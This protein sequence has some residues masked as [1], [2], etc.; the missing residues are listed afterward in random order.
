MIASPFARR[1][2]I[3]LCRDPASRAGQYGLRTGSE[4]RATSSSQRAV[5]PSSCIDS[6]HV[7]QRNVRARDVE[8][9][10][11]RLCKP[12]RRVKNPALVELNGN[13]GSSSA[14]ELDAGFVK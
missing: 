10:I 12:K 8:T 2:L 4:R 3:A 7:R 9:G 11:R 14:N 13:N 6:F 5:T 1:N